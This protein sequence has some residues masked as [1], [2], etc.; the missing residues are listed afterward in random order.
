MNGW[1]DHSWCHSPGTTEPI[2]IKHH[3]S[4]RGEQWRKGTGENQSWGLGFGKKKNGIDEMTC[5]PKTY[6]NPSS[7]GKVPLRALSH[8]LSQLWMGTCPIPIS[9][10]TITLCFPP[11]W[12]KISV[13]G[14]FFLKDCLLSELVGG[15]QMISQSQ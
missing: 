6:L 12:L 15:S 5:C 4:P 9:I 10:A 3:C 7:T 1:G 11:F 13:R 8:R 14:N 2:P